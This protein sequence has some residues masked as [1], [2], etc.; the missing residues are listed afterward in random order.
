MCECTVIQWFC[1]ILSPE[2][3]KRIVKEKKDN[4]KIINNEK[5]KRLRKIFNLKE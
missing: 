3:N 4:N 2:N 5:E 1:K